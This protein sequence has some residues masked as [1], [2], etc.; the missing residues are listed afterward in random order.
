[1]GEASQAID[2]SATADLKGMHA[3]TRKKDDP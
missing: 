2:E 3:Q 1:M